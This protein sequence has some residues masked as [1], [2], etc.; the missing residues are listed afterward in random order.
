MKYKGII[1][2]SRTFDALAI[3]TLLDVLFVAFLANGQA[4]TTPETYATISIVGKVV[5]TGLR[6]TTTGPIG[7]KP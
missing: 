3:L 6:I 7:Q 5:L 1:K 2:Q 4:L